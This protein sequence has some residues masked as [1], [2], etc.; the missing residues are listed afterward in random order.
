MR[1]PK[2]ETRFFIQGVHSRLSIHRFSAI[3]SS[4]SHFQK[5][6]ITELSL[7]ARDAVELLRGPTALAGG[8]AVFLA[9]SRLKKI[10]GPFSHVA[11]SKETSQL[12]D[13]IVT[14][15]NNYPDAWETRNIGRCAEE[16][17]RFAKLAGLRQ[18][19]IRFFES[20]KVRRAMRHLTL[21][22]VPRV[23][24]VLPAPLAGICGALARAQ[25]RYEPIFKSAAGWLVAVDNVH[26]GFGSKDFNTGVFLTPKPPEEGTAAASALQSALVGRSV[27]LNTDISD[28]N[29]QVQEFTEK[30]ED[31]SECEKIVNE[32]VGTQWTGIVDRFWKR[33]DEDGLF[34]D[35]ALTKQR[36]TYQRSPL[37]GTPTPV[38]LNL[39]WAF[40]K[41]K[42]PVEQYGP[43]YAVLLRRLLLVECGQ[44]WDK[45]AQHGF[46][47]ESRLS[48]SSSSSSS[49][50]ENNSINN[51]SMN[52]WRNRDTAD[53]LPVRTSLLASILA[54]LSSVPI[55]K[56]LLGP[57]GEASWLTAV[58]RRS[59]V[60]K[61]HVNTGVFSG[62]TGS[63]LAL[64][65]ASLP[66]LKALATSLALKQLAASSEFAAPRHAAVAARV[67]I[68]LGVADTIEG[69]ATLSLIVD[70]VRT[71]LTPQEA[72]DQH[73]FISAFSPGE[74]APTLSA[75]GALLRASAPSRSLIKKKEASL[76]LQVQSFSSSS[77]SSSTSKESQIMSFLSLFSGSIRVSSLDE[78]RHVDAVSTIASAAAAAEEDEGADGE[79]SSIVIDALPLSVVETATDREGRLIAYGD[80]TSGSGSGSEG[81]EMRRFLRRQQRASAF[82]SS[83]SHE[84]S[85]YS[86][87]CGPIQSSLLRQI[88][89]LFTLSNECVMG[90]VGRISAQQFVHLLCSHSAA[91]MPLTPLTLHVCTLIQSR[92][93]WLDSLSNEHL[94]DLAWGL[95]CSVGNE[96][97]DTALHINNVANNAY[98]K[99]QVPLRSIKRTVYANIPVVVL[100]DLPVIPVNKRNDDIQQT[101]LFQLHE[102]KRAVYEA[103]SIGFGPTAVKKNTA[104]GALCAIAERLTSTNAVSILSPAELTSI[105]WSLSIAGVYHCGLFD[106][107]VERL[108]SPKLASTKNVTSL[109]NSTTDISQNLGQVSLSHQN[110]ELTSWTMHSLEQLGVAASF[111]AVRQFPALESEQK[112]RGMITIWNESSI[113]IVQA[114]NDEIKNRLQSPLI[115]ERDEEDDEEDEDDE[116][117]D[118]ITKV[119]EKVTFPEFNQATGSQT[120]I[121]VTS[122]LLQSSVSHPLLIDGVETESLGDRLMRSHGGYDDEDISENTFNQNDSSYQYLR[123]KLVSCRQT[124]T[125]DEIEGQLRLHKQIE[126]VLLTYFDSIDS[127]R[128]QFSRSNIV[129]HHTGLGS[130]VVIPI[131]IPSKKIAIYFD[132]IILPTQ[133]LIPESILSAYHKWSINAIRLAGWT[134]ISFGKNAFLGASGISG[135]LRLLE[136]SGLSV[137]HN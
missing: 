55:D 34:R 121:Q 86:S 53:V 92:P 45:H 33:C 24:K 59:R 87:G 99:N 61:A 2:I 106:A 113:K 29:K 43:L 102:E 127:T 107:L 111:L 26:R 54:A 31:Y 115:L 40:A 117:Q 76:P 66:Q 6:P 73:A 11:F 137:S 10:D 133:M 22:F 131:A 75:L 84:T 101:K 64:E 8:D 39:L 81:S 46:A 135:K 80:S 105:I 63:A 69:S 44:T 97:S 91:C 120:I 42:M 12:M 90:N 18:Q 78:F 72:P 125:E 67:V 88:R 134:V 51:T 108:L 9:L 56:R 38:L 50:D 20:T 96:G 47:A 5:V 65:E 100:K 52:D 126:E 37:Q 70:R 130:S 49:T 35:L 62:P 116:N 57:L 27:E 77:S 123:T 7:V 98:Q 21:A 28:S 122:S 41:T 109:I 3:H 32:W 16:L 4:H 129:H 68:S 118:Q 136:S 83:I 71:L 124:D 1:R 48:S 132:D 17:T 82:N 23:S 95:A 58:R 79:I 110:S 93:D 25:I 103:N 89:L 15:L 119:A 112:E 94:I 13:A 60:G 14:S 74:L 114:V 36:Q 19:Q 128:V 104:R 30:I 85:L